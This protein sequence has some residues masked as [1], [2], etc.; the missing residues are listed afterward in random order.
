[1]MKIAEK[2]MRKMLLGALC[3]AWVLALAGCKGGMDGGGTGGESA[4]VTDG[5]SN[6]ATSNAAAT[7]QAAASDQTGTNSTSTTQ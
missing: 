2:T 4:T 1:M 3:T 5:N 7:N 6:A